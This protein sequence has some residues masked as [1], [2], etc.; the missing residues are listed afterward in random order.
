MTRSLRAFTLVEILIVVIILGIMA[1]I[2]IP[3]L[4]DFTTVSRESNL[5]ENLSKVRAYIQVYQNQHAGYPTA[6][7][8]VDQLTAYTNFDGDTA[9]ARSDEYRFG[10]YIERFPINPVTGSDTIRA[11]ADGQFLPPGD[12]DGG[13]WYNEATG[14]FYA[15]LTDQH[16]DNDGTQYNRF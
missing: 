12:Q 9:E 1:A 2:A 14:A 3:Q 6:D 13:W 11:A 4:N 5:K 7:D 8:L 10:P 15:D 16:T